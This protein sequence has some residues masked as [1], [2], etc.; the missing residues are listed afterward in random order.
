MPENTCLSRTY[1]AEEKTLDGNNLIIR[2]V[3]RGDKLA[4]QTI[5]QQLSP[6]SLY[7]RFLVAKRTLSERDLEYLTNIDYKRHVALV[8]ELVGDKDHF[9]VGIG[10]YICDD[11]KDEL[12]AEIAI[13]V[14]EDYQGRGIGTLLLR[15]LIKLAKANG[16]K[17]V[18]GIALAEN[19]KLIEMV[20]RL[21]LQT[22]FKCDSDGLM[23]IWIKL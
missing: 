12:S 22:Q 18:Y 11:S 21:R 7:M 8:A 5:M 9:P 19:R 6:A 14:E 20:Q 16:I 13:A 2:A 1:W 4:V 15:H 10:R 17:N 23:T 3:H